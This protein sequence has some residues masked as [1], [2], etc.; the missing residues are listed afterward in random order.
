MGRARPPPQIPT[1]AGC[2]TSHGDDLRTPHHP[3]KPPAPTLPAPRQRPSA[4]QC[5][6]PALPSPEH[7][8]RPRCH[9]PPTAGT[10]LILRERIRRWDPPRRIDGPAIGGRYRIRSAE[11]RPAGSNHVTARERNSGGQGRGMVGA[12]SGRSSTHHG[13]RKPHHGAAKMPP[14][15]YS[16]PK[17]SAI[18]WPSA[19]RHRVRS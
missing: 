3:Q 10:I 12:F 9:R 1:A 13:I 19:A 18:A 8:R 16:S 2:H 14:A 4:P 11:P 17:G 5:P 15:A 6:G 7:L